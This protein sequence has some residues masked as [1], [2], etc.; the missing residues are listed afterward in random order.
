MA[1]PSLA[2]SFC[3]IHPEY[4]NG[5]YY[6]I[7]LLG[8]AAVKNDAEIIDD[9]INGGCDVNYAGAAT[10][11]Y[12]QLGPVGGAT[13][14]HIASVEGSV[15][16]VIK[17]LTIPGIDINARDDY[18]VTAVYDAAS[19][20]YSDIITILF[21]AGADIEIPEIEGATPVH[22]AASYGYLDTVRTLSELGADLDAPGGPDGD[23]PLIVAVYYGYRSV[24]QYLVE[25]GVD[26][27]K[28]DKNRKHC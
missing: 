4:L 28:R 5:T 1:P 9:L 20:G 25:Q 14:L 16:V 24:V 8:I 10:E 2:Q 23:T 26:V 27:N 3:S 15:E 19:W 12:D 17:L 6:N 21:E 7:S 11:Y 13:P 18:G 22:V